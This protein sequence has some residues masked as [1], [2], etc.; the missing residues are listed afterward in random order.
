MPLFH[1]RLIAGV[2]VVVPPAFAAERLTRRTSLP[3]P[4]TTALPEPI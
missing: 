1:F 3:D 4:L 2:L